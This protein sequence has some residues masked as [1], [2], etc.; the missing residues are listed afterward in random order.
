MNI[1]ILDLDPTLCAEYHCDKHL[2]KM[3]TE[4]NQMLASV[5]YTARGITKKKLITPSFVE[6]YF[7]NFPRRKDSSPHPYGI[8]FVNHPCTQ[9][10]ASSRHNYN[11]LINLNLEMCKE[12][13]RRYKRVHAGEAITK[14]I[15]ENAP[16]LPILGQTEFPQAM[17]SDCKIPGDAVAAYR[18]YYIK[19]KAKFAK[20]AHTKTPDWFVSSHC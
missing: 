8:G 1:F 6:M 5:C 14:W 2:V 16:V 9:W 17:P 15:K 10:A 20:W 12:Y 13:T 4:H 19:Y 3:I 7:S 18:D 11:W